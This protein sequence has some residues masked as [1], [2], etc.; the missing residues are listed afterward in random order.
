LALATTLARKVRGL[1]ALGLQAWSAVLGAPILFAASFALE[2]DQLASM[3]H[4][5]LSAW[6]G[7]A[8]SA[9]AASVF[10]HGAVF[11]LVQR[12]PVAQVTPYLLLSPLVSVTLGI[13]VWGDRPGPKLFFG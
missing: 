3:R 12:Y 6:A 11:W 1:G 2:H 5:S 13:V 4:A 9:I 7:V 10:G 8:Y